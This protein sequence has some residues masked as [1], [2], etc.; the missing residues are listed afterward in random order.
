MHFLYQIMIILFLKWRRYCFRNVE[1]RFY[2]WFSH[3][4]WRHPNLNHE[5]HNN[6]SFTKR[7]Q[8]A[9]KK[10]VRLIFVHF[11]Q[12]LRNCG[13]NFT[14]QNDIFSPSVQSLL[15]LLSV[16]QSLSFSL[17][18]IGIVISLYVIG[19]VMNCRYDCLTKSGTFTDEYPSQNLLQNPVVYLKIVV[20][21]QKSV[22]CWSFIV[23]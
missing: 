13:G 2:Q 12:K 9:N 15:H 22:C 8:K 7:K 6:H 3:I 11:E 23:R 5:P 17:Y 20:K 1:A 19:T 16:N 14:F 18:F 4:K 10:S 21:R